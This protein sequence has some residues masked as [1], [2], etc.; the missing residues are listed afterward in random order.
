MRAALYVLLAVIMVLVPTSITVDYAHNQEQRHLHAAE[1]IGTRFNLPDV[2]EVAAPEDAQG[3]LT[4]A[5][6]ESGTNILRVSIESSGRQHIRYYIYLGAQHTQLFDIIELS[7]G[8]WPSATGLRQGQTVTTTEPAADGVIGVP[9]VVASRY[10]LS[11]QPLEAA[12]GRLPTAGT[13]TV[14]A[15]TQDARDAF[16][17]Y[18]ARALTELSGQEYTAA[19]LNPRDPHEASND[20]TQTATSRLFLPAP[21]LLMLIATVLLPATVTR[22]GKQLGA[23]SLHGYPNT[24]IWYAT[25][26]KPTLI[27]VGTGFTATVALTLA[28]PEMNSA[29]TH[30][31]FLRYTFTSVATLLVVY[32]VSMVAIRRIN[33]SDLVKGRL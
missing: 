4:A 26:G 3:V 6:D 25:T 13:Y 7:R 17:Q 16:L 24:R 5:A 10:E 23:L 15:T 27:A 14:E 29:L 9:N 31:L 21:Y 28:V 2:A 18:T 30:T 12:Y 22:A 33:V 8:A 19:D 32:S 1:R 11:I 20:R